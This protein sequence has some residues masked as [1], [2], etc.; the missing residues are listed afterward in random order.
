MNSEE[1]I[2]N[3]NEASKGLRLDI[4]IRDLYLDLSRAYIQKLIQDGF[5]LI[6]GKEVKSN[7]KLKEGQKLTVR[8]PKVEIPNILPENIPIDIIYEDDDIIIINKSKGISVH[9]SANEYSGTLV[10]ALLYHYPNNLS[11]I[12]VTDN[13]GNFR[14][15]I[16]H[17]LDKDTTGIILVCKTNYAH[18]FI[19]HQFK[20]GTILREYR[21][22]VY[23]HFTETKGEVVAPLARHPKD[24]IKMAIDFVNG[25]NS[26]TEYKVIEELNNN[27][28]YIKCLLKTGRTHQIRVHMASI[29]HPILGDDVYGP[30]KKVN[31]NLDNQVLHGYKLGFIHPRT[32]NYCEFTA[33]LPNYFDKLLDLLRR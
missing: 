11:D 32:N 25:K 26:I 15:G 21:A 6:D 22:I 24:R 29:S 12:N 1:R 3:I 20:A 28:T 10:N 13:L 8:L 9:P 33:N 4:F 31:F 19:A 27:Y 5:V 17:R 2:I 23:N 16:V 30:K 7:H 18:E 14:P